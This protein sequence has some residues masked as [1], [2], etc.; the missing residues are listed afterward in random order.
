MKL[1][2]EKVVSYFMS[3]RGIIAEIFYFLLTAGCLIIYVGLLVFTVGLRE[4]QTNL[5][6]HEIGV[7][8][9]KKLF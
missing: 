4:L 5:K 1:S 7:N 8:L 6:I 9:F 3:L 2:I